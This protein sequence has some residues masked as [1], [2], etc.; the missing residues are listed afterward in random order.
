MDMPPSQHCFA[1]T[2][3]SRW[4]HVPS[5]SAIWQHRKRPRFLPAQ[6]F[7]GPNHPNR[8]SLLG[9]HATSSMSTQVCQATGAISIRHVLSPFSAPHGSL[10]TPPRLL[11]SHGS[12]L[13]ASILHRPCFIGMNLS[14]DLH[15]IVDHH[16]ASCVRT[17][18]AN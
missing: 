17:S 2:Q 3:A 14:L 15:H 8:P 4:H 10:V 13:L 1:S 16:V 12:S 18:P 7:C 6:W 11:G 5:T 9:R